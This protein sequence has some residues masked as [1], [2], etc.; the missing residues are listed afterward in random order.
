MCLFF[1]AGCRWQIQSVT[2]SCH[3]YTGT[4]WSKE[5]MS[6]HSS[7]DWYLSLKGWFYH[8]PLLSSVLTTPGCT[9]ILALK[10]KNVLTVWLDCLTMS[11]ALSP[12]YSIPEHNVYTVHSNDI[13]FFMLI[14]SIELVKE[15]K[16]TIIC[17]CTYCSHMLNGKFNAYWKDTTT[18][19]YQIMSDL[20]ICIWETNLPTVTS[21]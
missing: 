4:H 1:R 17:I 15:K 11:H 13:C 6:K 18:P 7:Q 8:I 12:T 16:R 14:Y 3:Y 5:A 21:T 9:E 20:L 19:F 2:T 10:K